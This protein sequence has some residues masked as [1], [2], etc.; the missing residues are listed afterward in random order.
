MD[1]SDLWRPA[2]LAWALYDFAYSLFSFLLLV[3]FFPTWIID[4][5]GHPD[6][7]VAITQVVVV[8]VVVFAMPLAGAM[9]DQL[10]RRKPFLA[11]FTVASCMSAAALSFVPEDP[12]VLVLLIAGVSAA[13]GQLA[14]AQYDPILADVAPP[15]ARGRV[16]GLAVALGFAGI[17]VGLGVVAELIVGEGD[18]QR[19]FAPAAAFYLALALPAF[20]LIHER[21]HRRAAPGHLFRTGLLQLAESARQARRYPRVSRFLLGR[22]LYSDAIATLS[23][24]LTVYMSRLGGFSEREKNVV[25]GLVVVGAAAGAVA[26]GRLIERV[27]PRRLLLSVLPV[28]SLSIALSALVGEPWPVW[29]MGPV[30]GVGLGVVWTTDRVFM[31]ILTPAE[32]RGQFFGFFNLANRVASA[33][34]PLVVWSGTVWMLHQLTGWTTRLDASRVALAELAIVALVGWAV[35]RP[36]PDER[37][38]E[39]RAVAAAVA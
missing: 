37:R 22:F 28:V 7:Y 17:I 29:V 5:Q 8:L 23:V 21:T 9:A 1:R 4:D 26:A 2:P 39:E 11:A 6:W 34:G 19:A 3:R 38:A 12:V 20:L 33:V 30:A 36:L 24:F 15:E 27:G 13:S 31:L 18:K 16:S 25:L 32:L 14:L 35:I 10:G